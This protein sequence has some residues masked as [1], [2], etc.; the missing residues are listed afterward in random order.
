MAP[1]KILNEVKEQDKSDV[2][3]SLKSDNVRTTNDAQGPTADATSWYLGKK[4]S[5]VGENCIHFTFYRLPLPLFI[6]SP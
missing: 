6:A 3:F 2:A 5:F 1:C 4:T